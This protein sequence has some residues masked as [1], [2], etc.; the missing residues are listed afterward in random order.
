MSVIKTE[1]FVLKSFRYGETSKIVTLFTKD[2]G[3]MNAIVKGARNY[4]SKMSGIFETMNY[5]NSV[6]YIKENREL[7]LISNAEYKK[8]FGNILLDI[9]KLQSA[10][11]I[12]EILNKSVIERE[13]NKSIFALLL[14]VYEM[15]NQ[16]TENPL[17]YVLFFQMNLVKI[18]GLNP[19]FQDSFSNK[20]TFFENNE[21]SVNKYQYDILKLINE[22][23][24]GKFEIEES[25]LKNL[26]NCYEKYIL[27]HT[28]GHNYYNSSKVFREL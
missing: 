11:K 6:I 10:Y 3:K 9:N 27:Y 13:V 28:T 12:I 7:Q 20:E 22:N 5:I 26:N 16:L 8:S 1:A 25:V 2:F 4:K 24:L 15:L 23:I 17:L 21:F 18:L 14:N 19:E